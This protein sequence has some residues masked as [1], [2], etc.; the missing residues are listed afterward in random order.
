[1][2]MNTAISDS[3]GAVVPPASP[4][5]NDNVGMELR[6]ASMF[7]GRPYV[8]AFLMLA[9]DVDCRNSPLVRHV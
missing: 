7:T 1:M 9:S 8:Y 2:A 4:S 3:L 6:V 5:S